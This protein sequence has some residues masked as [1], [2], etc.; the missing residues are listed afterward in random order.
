MLSSNCVSCYRRDERLQIHFL[1]SMIRGVVIT[2]DIMNMT[3]NA[4]KYIYTYYATTMLGIR[5]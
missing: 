1:I 2:K 5:R 4:T 3:F